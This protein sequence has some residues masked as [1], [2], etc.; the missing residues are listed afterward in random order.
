MIKALKKRFIFTSMIAITLLLLILIGGI[1]IV[2]VITVRNRSIADLD[3]ISAFESKSP[4]GGLAKPAQFMQNGS[5][6]FERNE[7]DVF[8]ASNFFSLRID[9]KGFNVMTDI[10]R[11]SRVDAGEAF[12]MAIEM[13]ESGEKTGM[14]DYF[15]YRVT[16]LE[17]GGKLVVFLDIM[18]DIRACLTILIVS[19]AI[20]LVCWI[21]M[22]IVI[23]ILSG[24]A[25]KPIAENYEKQKQFVTNAGH[26]IKTPLAIIRSNTDAME[27]IRGKDKYSKNIKDQTERLA[28]LMNKLLTLAKMDE[29]TLKL[30]FTSVDLSELIQKTSSSFLQP[31][32]MKNI[33]FEQDADEG[34][35]AEVDKDQAELLMSILFDN[36]L[37]YTN[38]GGRI[39]M[40]LKQNGKHATFKLTNTC[41]KLPEVAPERLFDRFYRADVSHNQTTGG[42]GIGL[43][44]AK[45]VA[46]ALKGDI[47]AE[48][49]QP[50]TISF[51][52]NF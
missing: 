26:E 50:D 1:N 40:S 29:G 45:S 34:V 31:M 25:V 15:R 16:D 35:K 52:V 22:L 3:M 27:L 33:T 48:Y 41:E 24:R 36:A 12:D 9:E 10:S 47:K 39:N 13:I 46:E 23:I 18:P 44:V 14:V 8:M 43:S 17:N 21:F 42:S 28:D 11:T 4:E 51:T 5:Y 49:T 38:E 6:V 2:N 20:G 19:L 30:N 7:Y 37:K 32:E